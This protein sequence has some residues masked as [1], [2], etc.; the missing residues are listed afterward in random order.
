MSAIRSTL[1]D[2]R[3]EL[4]DSRIVNRDGAGFPVR[5]FRSRAELFRMTEFRRLLG[6][7]LP[8]LPAT[9]ELRFKRSRFILTSVSGGLGHGAVGNVNKI[10]FTKW[11]RAIVS[12]GIMGNNLSSNFLVVCNVEFDIGDG[13]VV[14]ELAAMGLAVVDH[15]KNDIGILIT[16]GELKRR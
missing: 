14:L 16:T 13:D 4:D 6:D 1:G 5:L 9:A 8:H 3:D 2:I 7:V 15:R 10:V 11:N 12:I